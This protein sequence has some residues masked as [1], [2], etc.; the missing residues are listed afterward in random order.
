MTKAPKHLS[1]QASKW[2]EAVCSEYE[3]APH[4]ILILQGAAESWDRMQQARKVIDQKGLTLDG[5]EKI[6]PEVK[7]E[8]DAKTLFLR[9]LR[10]LQLESAPTESYPRPPRL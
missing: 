2:F 9:A 5:G 6:R 10:E 7:A 8:N 3:L 1:A 4:H